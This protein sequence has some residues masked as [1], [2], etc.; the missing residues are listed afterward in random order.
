M[1]KCLW[2]VCVWHGHARD[3]WISVI[4]GAKYTTQSEQA[5]QDWGLSYVILVYF[6]ILIARIS[7]KAFMYS[8]PL[9]QIVTLSSK[10]E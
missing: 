4:R 1:Q 6:L 7:T 8:A 10:I 5:I 9:N 2:G 3:I